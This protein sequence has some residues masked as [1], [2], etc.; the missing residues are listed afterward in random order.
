MKE[1]R[2]DYQCMKKYCYL[3]WSYMKNILDYAIYNP[4]ILKSSSL[5]QTYFDFYFPIVP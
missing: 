1:R 2:A 4:V 5:L 3:E